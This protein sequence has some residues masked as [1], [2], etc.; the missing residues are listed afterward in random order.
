[1]DYVEFKTLYEIL[2]VLGPEAKEEVAKE[3]GIKR[4]SFERQVRRIVAYHENLAVKQRRS[5]KKIAERYMQAMRKVAERRLFQ[6]HT[7]N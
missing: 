7:V 4:S 6:L 3:L 5:G 2:N 1:M